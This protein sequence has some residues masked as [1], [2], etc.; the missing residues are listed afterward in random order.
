VLEYNVFSAARVGDLVQ[1]VQHNENMNDLFKYLN[2]VES[3][4][5]IRHWEEKKKKICFVAA[6]RAKISSSINKFFE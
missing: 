6:A 3:I 5:E 2:W 4:D 1:Q